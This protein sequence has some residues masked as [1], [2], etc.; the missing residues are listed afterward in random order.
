MFEIDK[1]VPI[2]LYYQLKQI[3]MKKI[4]TGEYKPNDR[5]PTEHELCSMLGMSRT[6]VRQALT[7]LTH[8]GIL[9]RRPGQGTFVSDFSLSPSRDIMRIRVL[10]PEDKWATP[11]EKAVSQWNEAHSERQVK[12]NLLLVG[13][14][15]LH[16]K[17]KSA[18]TSGSPPDFFLLDSVSVPNLAKEGFLKPL[19]EIDPLWIENDYRRDFFPVFVEESTYQGHIYAIPAQTDMAL[20]WYRR[21]WFKME[22]MEPPGTWEELVKTA[23]HFK[24]PSVRKKY[25]L[26]EYP[27]GFPGGLKAGETITY[28]FLPFLWSTGGDVLSNGRVVFDSEASRRA[29]SFLRDLVWKHRVVSPEVVSYEWDK[30]PK[31]FAKGEFALAIGGSYE[32]SIIREVSG[33]GDEDFRKRVG[34]VP[35]P[36]SPGGRCTTTAGGMAYAVSANAHDPELVLNILKITTGERFMR[37]FCLSTGQNPP[38]ISVQRSLDPE[39]NWFLFKTSAMI[40]NARVRPLTPEYRRIS[41]QLQVLL[42]NT[43]SGKMDVDEAVR[44]TACN[45]EKII[46]GDSPISDNAT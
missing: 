7:E 1:S 18:L 31:L 24:K 13:Y 32:S 5:L 22:G 39:K 41:E 46:G 21:D 38:R 3:I 20:I 27:L 19:D 29:L 16:F 14:P 33:F 17:I 26:K 37:A 9:Y 43:I 28:F 30:T 25:G 8:E 15:E 23:E 6:P 34:F 40:Y 4:E 42:E 12:L 10:V 36:A 45:L 11:L 44:R 2:P 35:I